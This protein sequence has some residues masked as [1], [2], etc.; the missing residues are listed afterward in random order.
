MST[1]R[2]Q[3]TRAAIG[4]TSAPRCQNCGEHVLKST[5]RVFGS[6]DGVLHHCA[7][8]LSLRDLKFGAGALPDYDPDRDRGRS[9][10]NH[11]IFGG[12]DE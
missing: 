3:W 12:P 6:N 11:D 9:S 10:E 8:C 5:V 2:L 1:D 4:D 7:S